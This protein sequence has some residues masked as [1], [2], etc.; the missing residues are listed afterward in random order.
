MGKQDF[1]PSPGKP[2]IAGKETYDPRKNQ[3]I[4]DTMSQLDWTFNGRELPQAK[5]QE[6]FTTSNQKALDY[7]ASVKADRSITT[8][9]SVIFNLILLSRYCKELKI[10]FSQIIIR[11]DVAPQLQQLGLQS[12]FSHIPISTSQ[13]FSELVPDPESE[14]NRPELPKSIFIFQGNKDP[15][16]IHV[17]PYFDEDD[18]VRMQQNAIQ[19][20]DYHVTAIVPLKRIQPKTFEI[21][22]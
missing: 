20:Y 18:W 8:P 15:R 5:R 17:E 11:D 14:V 19:N 7:L 3:C 16:R 12:A 2:N 4:F 6:M 13:D 22:S 9:E 10:G 21:S 1:Q